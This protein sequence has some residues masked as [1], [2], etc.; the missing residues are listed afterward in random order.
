M[1]MMASDPALQ[2]DWD[3]QYGD[4]M[5]KIVFIGQHMDKEAICQALDECLIG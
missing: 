3:D 5:Q 1:Q 2:R 4:R